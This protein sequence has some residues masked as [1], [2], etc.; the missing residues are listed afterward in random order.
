[1]NFP[2][3]PCK[4]YNTSLNIQATLNKN[5]SHC[6]SERKIQ[7]VHNFSLFPFGHQNKNHENTTFHNNNLIQTKESTFINNKIERDELALKY[8]CC[9]K[10]CNKHFGSKWVL[11]RH[12]NTHF[13]FKFYR[14]EVANCNKA[15]KS[16]ENYQI[17]YK[18]KHLSEKPF[19]CKFCDIKFS[20]RNGKLKIIIFL[21]NRQNLS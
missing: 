2:R 15:Y 21:I 9:F 6:L 8:T 11:D 12:H 10:G 16:K 20:H 4:I 13:V 18:N 5:Q 17:H 7:T 14:C 1:M 19:S 3:E